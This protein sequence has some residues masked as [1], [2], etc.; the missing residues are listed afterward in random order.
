[1]LGHVWIG[2]PLAELAAFGGPHLLTL[3]TVLL[4]LGLSMVMAR[5]W[6]GVAIPVAVALMWPLLNP[7]PAPTAD[8]GAPV[9]RLVQPNAPQDEKWDPARRMFYFDRM[10]GYTGATPAP[11]LTVWPETA[12]PVLFDD[13]QPSFD[14]MSEA[15]QGAPVVVGINRNND[16]VYHN[17]FVV[18]GRG[19]IV[20]SIYDKQH[21]VPFGEYI[22][23]G[24]WLSRIGITGFAPSQGGGFT[25]GQGSGLVQIAGI[26]TARALICYEGIFAEEIAQPERPR[27]MIL[28]T[29]DAWFGKDAGP[30]QHL[31][32]ARLRAIEQGLPMV[33]V[34]NTGIS[35]M[36]DAK[37][38]IMAQIP[39]D[40]AGYVDAALPPALPPTI[41]ARFGDLPVIVVIFGMLL[42]L[43]AF[44]RRN[45]G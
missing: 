44:G 4:S 27:L 36:I 39:L 20:Q 23:G 3:L 17:S 18:L 28:I 12:I 45:S 35:A 7:G 43:I 26:G 6:A 22:P 34:A 14:L 33:R 38:R 11:A 8:P 2:T 25:P 32:Q 19:G 30:T 29:N 1:L 41:Y 31:A 21:I 9:V 42:S 10:L 16:L 15:A 37:G 5:Q 13:A 40:T 24:E